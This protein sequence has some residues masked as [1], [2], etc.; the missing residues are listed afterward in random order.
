MKIDGKYKNILYELDTNSRQSIQSIGRKVGLHKN[1]V[2]HRIKKLEEKGIIDNYFTVIDSSKLGYRSYRLNL[3][4]QNTNDIIID[5]IINH[6]IK[7]KNTWWVVSTKGIY[8]FSTAIWVKNI[9]EFQRFW[10]QSLKK[11]HHYIRKQNFSLYLELFTFRHSYLLI[12]KYI[13]SD[14]TKYEIAGGSTSVEI[15]NIDYK[16]LLLLANNSRIP[17]IEISNKMKISTPT[18]RKRIKNLIDLEVIKGFRINIDYSK[19][20]YKMFKIDLY[21]ND[22]KKRDIILDFVIKNPRL[23]YLSNTL[24][25]ADFEFDVIVEEENQMYEI[26]EQ[27]NSNFPGLIKYYNFIHEYKVHKL[28]YMPYD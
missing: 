12:D 1:V 15:D 10:E 3:L 19:L 22:Y 28:D 7:Y 27:I 26:L 18:V 24:G 14:R 2:L 4:F 9:K 6:F 8:D 21:L 5:D 23:I 16:I 11:Y 17:T 13:K 25:Y 20:G